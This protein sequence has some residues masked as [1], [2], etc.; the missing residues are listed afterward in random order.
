MDPG[1]EAVDRTQRLSMGL[2]SASRQDL[3]KEWGEMSYICQFSSKMFAEHLQCVGLGW[4]W[5]GKV[6][7]SQGHSLTLASVRFSET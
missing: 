1:T 6:K 4:A 3:G 7:G 5:G 2:G